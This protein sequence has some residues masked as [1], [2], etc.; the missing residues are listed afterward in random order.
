MKRFFKLPDFGSNDLNILARLNYYISAG[1]FLFSVIFVIII[2]FVAPELTRRAT[3][4]AISV[5]PISI[6]IMAVVRCSKLHLAGFALT[7]LLWLVVTISS[8]TAGGVATPIVLGYLLV[9]MV[10]GVASRKTVSLF[11]AAICTITFILIA[12]AEINGFLPKPIE[13][14]PIAR[15]SVYVFFFIVTGFLQSINM[16]NTRD[17][18]ARTTYSGTRYRSLL[19]NIPTTTYINSTDANAKTEYVSPQ[20]E[21]LLGYQRNTFTDDPLYSGQ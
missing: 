13:Y 2:Q 11:A 3:A 19:E 6:F 12:L 4:I 5:I 10:G 15:T 7:I 9:I 21:K 8:I 20:V 14:T 17:L 18:I 1:L 16:L